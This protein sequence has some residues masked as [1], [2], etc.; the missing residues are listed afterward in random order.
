L[1]ILVSL[2]AATVQGATQTL[3]F[4]LI[5]PL[6]ALQVVPMVLLTVVPDGRALLQRLVSLDFVWVTI[7]LGAILLVGAVGLLLVAVTR[8]RR[9]R[10][11]LD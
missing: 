6:F 8:F 4:G 10:L 11:V 2:R 3:M 5:V 9:A 1:G 7:I